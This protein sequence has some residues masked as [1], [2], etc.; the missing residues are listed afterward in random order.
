[1]A[2]NSPSLSSGIR[3]FDLR[4]LSEFLHDLR[5]HVFVFKVAS[6][7]LM[8]CIGE[9]FHQSQPEKGNEKKI[10]TLSH[11]NMCV[12]LFLFFSQ[13]I[14]FRSSCLVQ[15]KFESILLSVKNK[16]ATF[17]KCLLFFTFRRLSLNLQ[18]WNR[19]YMIAQLGSVPFQWIIK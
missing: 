11:D 6:E 9:L 12:F 19:S 3:T 10:W 4:P 1:M 2:I 14:R 15:R 16:K 8:R 7:Q 13:K 5:S 18:L 17:Y